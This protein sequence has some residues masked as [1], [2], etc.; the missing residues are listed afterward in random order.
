MQSRRCRLPEVAGVSA[1]ADMAPN[2]GGAGAT[3]VRAERGGRP[4]T[5]AAPTVLI[6]PEGGWSDAERDFLGGTVD[7][8][9]QVLRAETAAV[10]AA[11]LLTALRV[12]LV[13]QTEP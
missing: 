12:G 11:S 10:A 5:L 13:T 7:L 8:G 3:M 9:V 2:A 4:P 6:G 1:L